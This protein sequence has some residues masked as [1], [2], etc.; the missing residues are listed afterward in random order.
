MASVHVTG[1]PVVLAEIQITNEYFMVDV[2][3]IGTG[4]EKVDTVQ[5]GDVHTSKGNT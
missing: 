5:V 3:P 1:I 4:T 2:S